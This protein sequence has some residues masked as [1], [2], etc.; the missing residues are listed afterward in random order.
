MILSH[1]VRIVIAQPR[2]K[3]PSFI[4]E[5]PLRTT[6]ADEVVLD[7]RLHAGQQLYNACLGEA[8]R[9]LRLIRQ[10][11]DWRKARAMPKCL[12]L[13]ASGKPKSNP[14]R[15][16]LFRAVITSFDFTWPAIQT[17]AETCRDA[18]WI[19]HHLGS[20]DT[21]TTSLRAFRAVQQH[22]FG[23]RGRPRFKPRHR[24]NSIEGKGD[25]VICFRTEPKPAIRWAGLLL[26]LMLDAKDEWQKRA[27]QARTKYVRVIRR[28]LRGRVRW[29]AQ[30]IQE[31]LPPAIHP[32][33]AGVVGL[34]LGPSTLAVVG[35][36]AAQL[37]P[38]CPTITQPWREMRRLERAQDRS[39]RAT[40]PGNYDAKG[41]ISKGKK[42]WL[43]S[44]RY[45]RR[46]RLRRET[47]RRLAAERRRSHGAL[48]NRILAQGTTIKTEKLNYKS[49]QKNYGRSVKVRAPGMLIDLLRRKAASAGGA[50]VDINPRTTKLSQFDHTTGNY[51]KKP[52]SQRSHVFGDGTAL[53]QRDLYSAFLATCCDSSTLDMSQV[54]A[55]WPAA[56]PLLRQAMSRCL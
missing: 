17:Y 18:C 8:L 26:P 10:S 47:E 44:Q 24:F 36:S 40:N 27:L 41:R 9:R 15:S 29:Y 7:K 6:A 39:R 2:I 31:G 28:D 23:K 22:A 3:T 53:V 43:R 38:L 1:Q 5:F 19:S 12:G 32:T 13:N 46:A 16:A 33:P 25:A 30:L 52:L 37:T 56:E 48:A 21:Q 20:H 34:D 42:R 54:L 55:T 49:W 50:M 51:V 4:A 45:L 14:A 11:I 35:A